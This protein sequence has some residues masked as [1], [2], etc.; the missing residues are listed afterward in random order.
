MQIK[1]ITANREYIISCIKKLLDCLIEENDTKSIKM[2][3]K[4]LYKSCKS[5]NSDFSNDLKLITMDVIIFLEERGYLNEK[6]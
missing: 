3:F 6:N 2:L 1:Y 5:N 4:S